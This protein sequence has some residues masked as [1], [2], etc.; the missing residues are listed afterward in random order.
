MI[1]IFIRLFFIDFLNHK[2]TPVFEGAERIGKALD[3]VIIFGDVQKTGRGYYR[4]EYVLL[5]E[6][7]KETKPGEI[8]ERHV[9]HLE[10]M[11]QA[12]PQYWLWSHRR[13]KR[14]KKDIQNN[15]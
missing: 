14:T 12:T 7:S 1:E 6:N 4:M 15:D 3:M 13:W 11:I 10:K 5:C 8:S 2:D 9:R